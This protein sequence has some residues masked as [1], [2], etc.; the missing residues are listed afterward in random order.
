MSK[1]GIVDDYV[2]Y[3]SP[4][5]RSRWR[6]GQSGN[7]TRKY[8]RK[9]KS[10]GQIVDRIFDQRLP[11][12]ENVDTRHVEIFRLII[13]MLGR[14]MTA[15][16]RK[17]SSVLQEY[18]RFSENSSSDFHEDTAPKVNVIYVNSQGRRVVPPDDRQ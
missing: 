2:G 1:N 17:A 15:G 12:T 14:A 3:K 16:N 10:I 11:V 9:P 8:A 13:A 5:R 18:L 7:P 4:P 6:K